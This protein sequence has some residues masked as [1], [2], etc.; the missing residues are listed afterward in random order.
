[1]VAALDGDDGS[2]DRVEATVAV[3]PDVDP[4]LERLLGDPSRSRFDVTV[5]DASGDEARDLE[6]ADVL[7]QPEQLVWP[8]EIEAELSFVIRSTL[9]ELDAFE[10]GADLGLD[11][12]EVEELLT[13]AP[14]GE[15]VV[16]DPDAP[17]DLGAGVG[18][19]AAVL[20]FIG[21]QS[22][23]SLVVLGVVEEKSSRVVEVLLSHVRATDLLAGKVLGVAA[24]A[25]VQ[26]LVVLAGALAALVATDAVDVSGSTV[27][28]IPLVAVTFV[29]GFWFYALLFALAGSLVSRQE[30]AQQI[31]LPIMVPLFAGYILGFVAAETPGS[32][33]ARTAS[34]VPFTSPFVLPIRVASG[35]A[36]VWEIAA[37]VGLLAAA[38]W[39]VWGLAGR[40]YEFTLLRT[41]SRIPVRD[42]LRLARSER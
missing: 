36:A 22:Y 10:R 1:M 16:D 3:D 8:G 38:S 20:T 19:L 6:R 24:L 39:F 27:A 37:A 7:V 9:A 32:L 34:I 42:V 18:F 11:P 25:I 31:M 23:G 5:I 41:G 33:L 12:G 35:D 29:G 14:V 13:P 26:L 17:A 30:D 15:R 2:I 4:G 40:V 28:A 21:I